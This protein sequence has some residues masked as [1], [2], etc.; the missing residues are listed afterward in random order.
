MKKMRYQGHAPNVHELAYVHPSAQLIGEVTIA[1]EASVWPTCVMRG[2]N[3]AIVLGERSNFQDGSIAHATLGQSRTTVGREC[4][5]GHR[6]VLHGCT[7]GDSC[8]VGIGAIVL[9]NAVLGDWCFV[10]AGSLIPPGRKFPPKSF[11]M[12]SPAKV[13]REA[14]SKDLEWIAHSW[15]VYQE[16]ARTYRAG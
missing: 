12:G 11:I 9:D 6:V 1:A 5:I 13:V 16:L 2:D 4:T 3:G 15:R 14:T 7:V 10:A 8:L